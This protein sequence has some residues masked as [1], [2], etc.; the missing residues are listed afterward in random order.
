MR[1]YYV[2]PTV[3]ISESIIPANRAA[4]AAWLMHRESTR[5]GLQAR[6]A[7]NAMGFHS[8][9]FFSRILIAAP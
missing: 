2:S 1:C 7:I 3:Y 5:L 4:V 6:L 8:S 9:L